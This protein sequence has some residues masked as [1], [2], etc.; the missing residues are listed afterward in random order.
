MVLR[1][2]ALRRSPRSKVRKGG[3]ERGCGGGGL[4]ADQTG[5]DEQGFHTDC[6]EVRELDAAGDG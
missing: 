5:G 2:R 3:A 4:E 6:S 1:V